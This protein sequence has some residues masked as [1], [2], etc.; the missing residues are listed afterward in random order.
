MAKIIVQL[1]PYVAL[2]PLVILVVLI[3]LCEFGIHYAADQVEKSQREI[4]QASLGCS[5]AWAFGMQPRTG[6]AD[7]H[8]RVLLSMRSLWCS[9][10]ARAS[11]S[12]LRP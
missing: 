3:A 6:P 2:V 1:H 8:A 10:P 4:T 12:S 5:P 9:W 11:R 7:L